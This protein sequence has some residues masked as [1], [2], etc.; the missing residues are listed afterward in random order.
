MIKGPNFYTLEEIKSDYPI[1]NNPR[2]AIEVLKQNNQINYTYLKEIESEVNFKINWKFTAKQN[3]N[4][5][6]VD[7][8]T[9]GVFP[10]HVCFYEMDNNGKPTHDN[11][12]IKCQWIGK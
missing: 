12:L 9:T 1:I 8:S 4:V 2:A 6:S 10:P 7:M 5:W 11:Y 3:E